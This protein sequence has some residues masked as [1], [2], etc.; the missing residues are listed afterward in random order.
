MK[1]YIIMN[2]LGDE[3]NAYDEMKGIVTK[4]KNL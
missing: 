3:R 1:K 4:R 2:I